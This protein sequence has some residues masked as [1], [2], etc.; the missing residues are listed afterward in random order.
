MTKYL[1][2]IFAAFYLLPFDGSPVSDLHNS[3]KDSLDTNEPKYE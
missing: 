3:L 2:C 1:A